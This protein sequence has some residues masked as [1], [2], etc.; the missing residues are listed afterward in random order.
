[1]GNIFDIPE[2]LPSEELFETILAQSNILIERIIS[3]GQT[4]PLGQ[5]YDQ[6]TD[7]W[8][9]LLQGEAE[10]SYRDGTRL[11][12]QTGDYVMIPA[13]HQHRV[14]YTSSNPVCIW[15]AIHIKHSHS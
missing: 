5:W 3:S 15:L 10:L 13:H 9:I 1:M 4:T 8:V 11:T 7:E 12:M 2:I 14:E 6:E